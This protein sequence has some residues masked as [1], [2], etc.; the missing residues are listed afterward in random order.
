M[1]LR[2]LSLDT[3]P[4]G[5]SNSQV[6]APPRG[7]EVTPKPRIREFLDKALAA[8]RQ[9]KARSP[10]SV[11]RKPVKLTKQE[12]SQVHQE[13]WVA[14]AEWRK[15]PSP[16]GQKPAAHGVR[17]ASVVASS[18]SASAV[19][20]VSSSASAVP[21]VASSAS[22]GRGSSS[23]ASSGP[24]SS[25]S[26]SVSSLV[27]FFSA[28]SFLSPVSSPS[29]VVSAPSA[30]QGSEGVVLALRGRE[31]MEIE[32]VE[33]EES[34]LPRE[35]AE[36]TGVLGIFPAGSE[37]GEI[38]EDCGSNNRLVPHTLTHV[39]CGLSVECRGF[40]TRGELCNQP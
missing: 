39:F 6:T 26:A 33:A 34:R 3:L 32:E 11:S 25:S 20:T 17:G 29:A 18:S 4:K 21:A 12:K 22:V 8:K 30:P 5:V 14:M 36:A 1:C 16:A 15:M 38:Y 7:D 40:D 31:P 35:R 27:E 2:P 10:A 19:P 9:L 37:E 13:Y 24:A 23:S 28:L